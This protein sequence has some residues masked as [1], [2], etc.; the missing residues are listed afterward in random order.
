MTNT[1]DETTKLKKKM[2]QKV[3]DIQTN[4]VFRKL[5]TDLDLFYSLLFFSLLFSSFLF[6]FLFSNLV[7]SR[8]LFFV[9]SPSVFFRLFSTL[10]N[11]SRLVSSRLVSSLLFYCLFSSLLFSF[12]LFTSTLSRL[13]SSPLLSFFPGQRPTLRMMLRIGVMVWVEG[14]VRSGGIEPPTT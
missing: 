11:A 3:T 9:S 6:D 5:Q 7:L 2:E 12:I 14:R 4:T 13:M 10:F 8:L 1:G